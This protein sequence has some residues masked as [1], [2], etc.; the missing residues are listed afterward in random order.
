MIAHTHELRKLVAMAEE[1]YVATGC[2]PPANIPPAIDTTMSDADLCAKLHGS[3]IRVPT[4]AG[5]Y[6]YYAVP[7]VGAVFTRDGPKLE[8]IDKWG[9]A[10]IAKKISTLGAPDG[11]LLGV[12]TMPT[13]E[14]RHA[15]TP[16]LGSVQARIQP[17]TNGDAVNDITI[18]AAG[19]TTVKDIDGSVGALGLKWQPWAGIPGGLAG[20]PT[21]NGLPTRVMIDRYDI[22]VAAELGP[23]GPDQAMAQT[24][25]RQVGL[26]DATGNATATDIGAFLAAIAGQP[27]A[28]YLLATGLAVSDETTEARTRAKALGEYAL[29]A[30]RA[31]ASHLDIHYLRAVHA[32]TQPMLALA[33]TV[34]AEQLGAAIAAEADAQAAAAAATV[35]LIAPPPGVG[36]PTPA[37]SAAGSAGLAPPAPVTDAAI[38][39]HL[40]HLDLDEATKAA[41]VAARAAKLRNEAR[42]ERALDSGARSFKALRPVGAEA[43]SDTEILT[44][45]ASALE[46]PVSA[47]RLAEELATER[48]ISRD[49][50]AA[51]IFGGSGAQAMAAA[52]DDWAVLFS[53][54]RARYESQPPSWASAVDRLKEVV[55]A[56]RRASPITPDEERRG[57]GD[58]Q[59]RASP[60]ADPQAN[61]AGLFKTVPSAKGDKTY[62][63][64]GDILTPLAELAFARAEAVTDHGLDALS[65]VRRLVDLPGAL[66]QAAA[67][68]IYSD[69]T[70]YGS[71][72]K[73]IAASIPDARE[74]LKE[75]IVEQMEEVATER[76]LDDVGDKIT[77]FAEAVLAVKATN[78]DGKMDDTCLYPLAVYLLGGTPPADEDSTDKDTIGLGS[79][80]VR[81]GQ[82]SQVDIPAA[83][84]HLARILAAVHG[85]A[86]GGPI[87]QLGVA[88]LG[89]AVDGL[90]LTALSRRACGS[91][92]PDRVEEM[93][94]DIF[95][96]AQNAAAK[97]RTRRGAPPID[98]PALVKGA[99][100]RKLSPLLQE[101]RAESAAMRKLDEE[102]SS[103]R[104]SPRSETGV[105]EDDADGKKPTKRQQRRLEFV[106]EQK[107]RT[108]KEKKSKEDKKKA[109]Q[110]ARDN[111]KR[112]ADLLA[113]PPPGTTGAAGGGPSLAPGSITKVAS[114]STHDGAIEAL[115]S[116]YLKR[117]GVGQRDKQ[118]CPFAAIQ[119]TSKASS[120]AFAEVC[121]HKLKEP[122]TCSQC[123]GWTATPEADRVP[124]AAEDIAAVKAACTT[125]V[126]KAFKP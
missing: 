22:D 27:L 51:S 14:G 45:L 8:V 69:G 101:Q 81:T 87:G 46:P 13:S 98:W 9:A 35:P 48:G 1:G 54:A 119:H 21:G 3:L 105:G 25:L 60:T 100:A 76:R 59:Q 37:P 50:A 108:E 77:A 2:I 68:A 104:K 58:A 52:A 28:K 111:A 112:A 125:A 34:G 67:A 31:T 96:R 86:G 26:I 49:P 55:F 114:K 17:G 83:M 18:S 115:Q 122:F 72:P 24:V 10:A 65:E 43:L 102:R 94:K 16:R 126:Q 62:A 74:W 11:I 116:L 91:L 64:A 90:G 103:G 124:Y 93:M 121:G 40:R 71:L 42:A 99:E 4:A 109:E 88:S 117:T 120:K 57:E 97:R 106:E 107:L 53:R 30:L 6:K 89:R 36:D 70:A 92:L 33:F 84:L 118:P 85:T 12:L 32:T 41:I 73:G 95:R 23:A 38:E 47:A 20:I 56:A 80:G 66:G 63:A 78:K 79:W 61:V 7:A 82:Q 113:S 44:Q 19:A 110:G 15:G 29:K 39:A 5:G 75:W 123:D